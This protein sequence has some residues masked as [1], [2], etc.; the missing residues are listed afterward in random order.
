MRALALALVVAALVVPLA[1]AEPHGPTLV[2]RDGNHI[3]LLSAGRTTELP[4]GPYRRLGLSGDRRLV[5]IGGTIL[6]RA[7][8]PTRELVWAPT[9][10]RAAYATTEGAVVIWTPAGKR[11]IEPRGWGA[12]PWS[13]RIGLA[14]SRNGALAIGRGA[15]VWVWR[16]GVAREA[17]GPAP[18]DRGTGGPSLA[19]PFAW[20]DGNVLWWAWPG[21]GSIASDG[22]S[23]F[24]GNRLLGKTLMYPDYVAACGA[25][26]AIAVGGNRYSTTGKSIVFDG[27]PVSPDK[28]RSWTSPSCTPGGRL[29]AT[30]TRNAYLS[31]LSKTHRAIWQLLPTRKQLTRPPWGWSDESPQLLPNGDLLFVRSRIHSVRNGDTWRDTAKGRVMVLSHGKLRQ[32]AAIG[33]VQDEDRGEYLGPYYGHWDWS[34]FLAVA[35]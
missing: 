24:E 17:A 34:Q 1:S 3:T 20:H 25:H 23:L 13:G 35:P 16:N 7:K 21:S 15:H 19:L 4:A 11:T 22:V 33:Y 5:S 8:L 9:G 27:R 14:W 28:R 30:E 2:G 18:L 31:N 10:E 32:M 29:V 6:G 12:T 26:V